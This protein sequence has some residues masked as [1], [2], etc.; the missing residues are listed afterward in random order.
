MTGMEILRTPDERFADLPGYA[1]RPNYVA[2]D[3]LRIHYI[4]EGPK[5]SAPVLLMHGEPSWCYLYRKMVP[6]LVDA[7]HRVLAPDLV[8]F[9]RS[10]KPVN[11]SDY[12][13]ER[14]VHWM[15]SW[16]KL[17]DLQQITLVGQDWGSLIGLRLVAEH[18]DRFG[19]VVIANGGL[20]AGEGRASEAFHAWKK[21][22]ASSPDFVIGRIV[23]SGCVS[24]LAPEV[25]AAY[26]APFPS[27]QYKA[28]ARAFPNLVPIAPDDPAVPANRVA[29]EKLRVWHK[30]FLT[31]FSDNDPITQGGDLRFQREVPGCQGQ[32]HTTIRGAGH[33]LQEDKSEELAAVVRDFI[34]ITR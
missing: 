4:D 6:I 12:S 15:A 7:G 1:Y 9:G 8:G 21:F 11:Q 34:S 13:F 33:F 14:H 26:D 29:W 17:L 10:D 19:R 20:P 28:G 2:V 32:P 23:A 27:E 25:C 5:H 3:G 18:G 31:A 22:A 24:K 16:L 30:P